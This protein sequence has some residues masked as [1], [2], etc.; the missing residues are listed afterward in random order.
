VLC[1]A[2]DWDEF[3]VIPR[4]L[5]PRKDGIFLTKEFPVMKEVGVVDKIIRID[6][7]YGRDL[8]LPDSD[9]GNVWWTRGMPDPESG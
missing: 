9:D 3:I 6:Y 7:E 8:V 1:D 5:A 4:G 2:K